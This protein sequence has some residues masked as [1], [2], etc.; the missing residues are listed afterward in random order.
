LNF[1]I[2]AA[3]LRAQI[4]GLKG[5]RKEAIFKKSH[6]KHHRSRISS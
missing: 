4:Y 2:A 3:N 5:D 6:S 1:V